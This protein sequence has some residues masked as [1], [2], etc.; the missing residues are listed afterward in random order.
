MT[1]EEEIAQVVIEP[2][3]EAG[4]DLFLSWCKENNYP[5]KIKKT[6]FQCWEGMHD[7]PRHYGG[8]R[9]DGLLILLAPELI[10][11]PESSAAAII[12]H[13]LGH[14][15]DFL[16]PAHFFM[17][18]DELVV[19]GDTEDPQLRVARMKQWDAR[20]ED[21]VEFVAD[22]IVELVTGNRIGYRG[23]CLL[24]TLNQGEPRPYGLR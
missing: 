20:D 22:S 3:F 13:E 18:G 12:Q 16:F 5:L 23:P 4:R 17:D 6:V 14:A 24:Q 7:S 9:D 2:Y 15:L 1:R 11:L 21:T 10:D 8:C 19:L